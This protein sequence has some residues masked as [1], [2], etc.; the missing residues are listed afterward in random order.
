MCVKLYRSG[1]V[2]SLTLARV[3][4]L[5]CE[6]LCLSIKMTARCMIIR[7]RYALQNYFFLFCFI[8]SLIEANVC[9][10]YVGREVHIGRAVPPAMYLT[11]ASRSSTEL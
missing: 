1:L 9:N 5:L 6:Q 7:I 8:H 2:F 4:F 11:I 3:C 10:S